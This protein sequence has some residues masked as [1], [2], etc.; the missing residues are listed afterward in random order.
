[1]NSLFDNYLNRLQK[2]LR[3][4]ANRAEA[5]TAELRDHLESQ[6]ADLVDQGHDSEQAEQQIL[7]ELGEQFEL[8]GGF[9]QVSSLSR[10]RWLM[11]YS[12]LTMVASFVAIVATISLWPEKSRFG[13]P[14]RVTAQQAGD[15]FAGGP[16]E[17]GVP[18]T[19][20][21]KQDRVLP[22]ERSSREQS[23][24]NNL[25]NLVLREILAQEQLAA[26]TT[27]QGLFEVL[28]QAVDQEFRFFVDQSARDVDFVLDNEINNH[29]GYDSV[30]EELRLALSQ[31]GCALVIRGKSV[32]IVCS[33]VTDNPEFRRRQMIDC[34]QLL[35]KLEEAESNRMGQPISSI[36]HLRT[37]QV[38][39]SD[40]TL[41][42]SGG[43]FCIPQ[44][45][46]GAAKDDPRKALGVA[47]ESQGTNPGAA[48]GTTIAVSGPGAIELGAPSSVANPSLP[49][50]PASGLQNPSSGLPGAGP[51]AAGLAGNSG[52][53]VA[54]GGGASDGGGMGG[55]AMGMGSS[56]GGGG[57]L[58]GGGGFGYDP[59]LHG[60]VNHGTG[61]RASAVLTPEFLL[62][63]TIKKTIQPSFWE[64]SDASL[65]IV[66]G[67]LII[68]APE[69]V[70]YDVQNFVQDFDSALSRQ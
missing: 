17:G 41:Q 22:S 69:E 43:F 28:S 38:A 47:G 5:I 13:A 51:G 20:P 33:D 1:M 56:R 48:G 52:L 45:E 16:Q 53:G 19:P 55:G 7:A 36:A 34:R 18:G 27:W 3:L 11:R 62:L 31:I 70:L 68:V 67:M 65:E 24:V 66:G 61:N 44:Q 46:S 26:A 14:D 21:R 39:A 35:N 32:V 4:S 57:A 37:W 25:Q 42:G 30:Y 50:D 2:Q 10:R 64:S 58:G 60:T 8:A 9:N 6:L 63:E 29:W 49:S 59:T 54:P 23:V 12:A 15:P 40:S